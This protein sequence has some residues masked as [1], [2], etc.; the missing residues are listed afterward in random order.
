MGANTTGPQPLFTGSGRIR[1]WPLSTHAGNGL[2]TDCVFLTPS[3]TEFEEARQFLKAASIHLHLAVS[4]S[5]ARSLLVATDARVLL[6]EVDSVDGSWQ[7]ALDM[8]QLLHPPRALV[9]AGTHIDEQFW[10]SALERGAFDVLLMPFDA[11]EL[12]RIIENANSYVSQQPLR[13]RSWAG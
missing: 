5:Q 9:A 1:V 4:L 13:Y 12:K 11:E 2:R 10:I 6:A 8:A 7:R 3:T